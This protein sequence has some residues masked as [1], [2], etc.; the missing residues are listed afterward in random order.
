MGL[1]G[2]FGADDQFSFLVYG[3]GFGQIVGTASESGHSSDELR[4]EL[5]TFGEEV[6]DMLMVEL[7][8]DVGELLGGEDDGI[9][10][11]AVDVQ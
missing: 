5:R 6:E 1:S 4:K 3:E 11:D 7:G 10:L 2:L 9:L 8:H